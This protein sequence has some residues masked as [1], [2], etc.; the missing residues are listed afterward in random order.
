MLFRIN[1]WKLCWKE[2]LKTLRKPKALQI[3]HLESIVIVLSSRDISPLNLHFRRWNLLFWSCDPHCLQYI[4]I[5]LLQEAG[6]L[7]GM[8]DSAQPPQLPGHQSQG[9]PAP[10]GGR[11]HREG[12][13]PRQVRSQRVNET[14]RVKSFEKYS[15]TETFLSYIIF[16]V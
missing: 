5:S 12:G 15:L 1:T 2:F 9:H 11:P 7:L 14:L 13:P 6:Q 4:K 10:D 8:A 3:Y 16:M